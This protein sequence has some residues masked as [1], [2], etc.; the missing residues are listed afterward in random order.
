M[1]LIIGLTGGIGSGKTSATNLFTAEG[2]TIIDADDI[3]HT[4]T[5][6]QGVAIPSI[7]KEFGHEFFAKDGSLYRDKMR[8][9]IFTNTHS[10]KKLEEILHP[11][12]QI[13]IKRRIETS[14]SPYIIISVPLLLE[15]GNYNEEIT[16]ILV[17]DC[18]EKYQI[19]RTILRDGK[20]EQEVRAIIATQVS[21]K[22]R[23]NKAD[24]IIVNNADMSTLR[25][26]VKIQHKKYINLLNKQ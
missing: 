7:R 21:R 16:R 10:R 6:K 15:T 14:S 17:I 9:I 5:K 4:L 19:T 8:N 22:E 3:A 24:D 11:L 20:N 13:E 23:I 26:K 25:N 18:D 2:V 1:S 12:I